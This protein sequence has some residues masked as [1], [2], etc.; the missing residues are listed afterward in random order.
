[1]IVCAIVSGGL[2][3]CGGGGAGDALLYDEVAWYRHVV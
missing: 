3:R 2:V 1:M